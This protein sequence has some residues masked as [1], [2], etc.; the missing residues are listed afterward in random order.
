L[1]NK[2]TLKKKLKVVNPRFILAL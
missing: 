2:V 1:E